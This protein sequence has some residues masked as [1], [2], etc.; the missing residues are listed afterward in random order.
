M[1]P[2]SVLYSGRN[3]PVLQ[4]LAPDVIDTELRNPAWSALTGPQAALAEVRGRARRFAP[5]ISPFCALPADAGDADWADLAELVGPGGQVV[6]AALPRPP[7]GW[8][9]AVEMRGVQYV[10]GPSGTAPPS[11][12]PVGDVVRLGG[13]DVPEMLDL[14]ART[15]PGP[16]ARRTHEL[17]GYLGVRVDGVLVAMAGRRLRVPGGIEVS[18]VCTAPELRGRGLAGWLTAAVAAEIR[19]QGDVPFLHA[20]A[21]NTGALRLYETLGFSWRRDMVFL[22]LRA[23]VRPLSRRR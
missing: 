19:A 20:L 16:F 9:V 11:A 18:G 21:S 6:G 2:G 22:V 7:A 4:Q 17:G 13:A 14:V 23:P 3:T 1:W 8:S 12:P 10:A 15:E 5:E